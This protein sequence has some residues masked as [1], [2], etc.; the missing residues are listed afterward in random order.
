MILAVRNAQ[1]ARW[2]SMI[3]AVLTFVLSLSLFTGY[4]PG[5]DA[6]QFV[7]QRAWIPAYD[8]GYN[9]GV[10]G[11]A[12]ALVLLTTLVAS[13]GAGRGVGCRSTNA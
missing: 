4:D 7:E 8:I 2:A 6:L 10:D 1:A 11:I 9:L 13:A 12:I 5:I 3:V